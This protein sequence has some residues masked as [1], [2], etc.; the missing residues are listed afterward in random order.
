MLH[1]DASFFFGQLCHIS[2]C[3]CVLFFFA[4]QINFLNSVIVDLQRK[5]EELKVKLK[6]MVL[7]E[8]TGNDENNGWVDF[9][10]D[11]RAEYEVYEQ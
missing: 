7:A 3:F 5:N 4:Q 8:F 11:P 6:K 2:S 10:S 1:I 9:M